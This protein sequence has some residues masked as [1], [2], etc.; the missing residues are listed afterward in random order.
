MA[1]SLSLDVTA[2]QYA[3]VLSSI[4]SRLGLDI[5]GIFSLVDK[6]CHS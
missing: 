6:L 2:S 5:L 3:L 4:R 1:L